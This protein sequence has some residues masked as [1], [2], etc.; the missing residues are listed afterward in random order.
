M[1]IEVR[2]PYDGDMT[3]DCSACSFDIV[4]I[5]AFDGYSSKLLDGNPDGKTLEVSDLVHGGDYLFVI[6]GMLTIIELLSV[7]VSLNMSVGRPRALI[8]SLWI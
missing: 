1:E 5:T 3:M 8:T 4:N 7:A 6:D 2:M